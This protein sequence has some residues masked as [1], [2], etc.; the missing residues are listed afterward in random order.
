MKFDA[1]LSIIVAAAAFT[2]DGATP[3]WP[4]LRGPNSSGV[5]DGAKPP[6]DISPT[7]SVL[8]KVQ[9]PWSPSSPCIW[10][11]KIFLTT[12]S[13]NELQTRCYNRQ[14]GTL[15]WSKGLKPDKL[16]MFHSTES[17][18]AVPTPATDGQRLVSYFGSFGLVCYDLKGTE[19]RRHQM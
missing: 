11:D 15:V 17:S 13:D 4:G 8:W 5:G 10:D 6:T 7:N 1:L 12:F 2:A 18:P 14:D 9:V 3:A 16:E 19:L